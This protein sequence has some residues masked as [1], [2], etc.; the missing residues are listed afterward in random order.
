MSSRHRHAIPQDVQELLAQAPYS[1]VPRFR[2]RLK[3]ARSEKAFAA[4]TKDL[5][6]SVA[7]VD[8]RQAA[9]PS[10][11]YPEALP[12][13][14]YREELLDVIVNNQVVIIAG[15]TG[16]G[17]TTQI[18][19]LCLELG[20]GRRGLIGHTQPRRLA[21]RTVAERIAEELGQDIGESVGYA[22][23]FD[24]RVS[25]STSVKLM[26]DGI[27]LAEMQRDRLLRAYD[28]IIIDEAHERS[29]NIDFLLGYLKQLLPK[30]PELKVI[31]TSAT[32]DPERFAEHF[33]DA[34]GTPAPI[35]EVSGRTY[36]V[37][38]LYRPL[39]QTKGEKTIDVDPL[40]GLIQACKELMS[41]GP[42]DIL[43]FFAG[44][45][46]IR[47]AME[48]IEKQ[49]WKGVEVT[50]LFG[51]LSNQEQHKVF[52]PHAGRRIV[53]A[54]NIAETSLTVPGIHYVVDTGFAR[55]SRYSTRTKVQRL[56]I[57]PISQAS[58]NQRSGRCGRVADGVAI[59][60][61]SEQD[62]QSRPEFT[63][64][65][66]LRTNLAQVILQMASLKLGDIQEF[67]FIQ[68]PD[69]KA[70]RD[71]LLL[72]HELDAL[73]QRDAADPVLTA[74]GKQLARIPLD[75]RLARMLI[76]AQRLGVLFEAYVVVA[77]LTIQDVRERPLEFQAQADQ[78]H[79]RFS[80]KRSDFLSYINLWRYIRTQ[81][82]ELSGNAF[83]KLMQQ[84]F[85]HYMRIREWFDLVR[86]LRSIAE[87]LGWTDV[88]ALPGNID[89]DALHRAVLSGLLSHIGVRD[90]ESR[91]YRGSRN[92]RFAIFPGSSVSKAKPDM[93]MAAEMVETSRLWARDVAQI[94]PAWVEKLGANL[95]KHQYS[96]PFWSSKRAQPMVHQRSTLYGVPVVEDRVIG[97][98]NVDQAAARDMFI[99]E[100]LIAGHWQT[101]HSFYHQNVKKLE[102]A[103]DLEEKAR[104]RDIVVDEETL[105]EFYDA[106]LPARITS[107][108]HFDHWWKKTK[109]QQPDLLDFDP[110]ALVAEHA[111]AVTEEAFPD[112]WRQGSL[113]YK[114]SYQFDPTAPRDGVTIEIPVPLLGGLSPEGF[115]WL[116]P[117]LR[118]ELLTEL[119]R[120]LPKASRRS[121]VPAP[122]F[123]EKA[124]EL[125]TAYQGTVTEQLA[126][127]LQRLGGS[128]IQ[129]SDFQVEKLPA[130]LRFS[131]AA[132][133]KRGKIID[134]DKDLAR[135][136]ERQR[137]KIRSSVSKAARQSESK[138]YK[139]WTKDTIGALEPE[140]HTSVE[141]QT[142]TAYPTLVRTEQGIARKVMP[143]KAQADAQ[144]FS[145]T[146]TM[147]SQDLPQQ[148]AQMLK[149]LP[150]R[151][152]VAVDK[153]PHGGA[154]GLLRDIRIAAIRDLMLEAGG[155]Q[156]TPEGYQRLLEQIRPQLPSAVRQDTVALAPA[157]AAWLDAKQ[158]LEGWEGPA[159]EDMQRQLQLMLPEH[160]VSKLGAQRLKHI[161]RYAKAI[162]L[163]LEDM[164]LHPSRD[165]E[166]QAV[167]NGLEV[168]LARAI[169]NRG[170]KPQIP[171]QTLYSLQWQLQE[172]RVS[173][174]AQ[175]LGTAQT[176]SERKIQ[177]AID[178]L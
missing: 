46:D 8:A 107:G 127:A 76:E 2:A 29:L 56:P 19:K 27:L 43:C 12:V 115:D 119:I 100:A 47:D 80:N 95:L 165:A 32:I 63:D 1:A 40:D 153:Y 147:L 41:Y 23:R 178:A 81:R 131:F 91:E 36:P 156:R 87:Q 97:Y 134:W 162:A 136:Q 145:T 18:P 92:T 141:G 90:G 89:A 177:K 155:P 55:I 114:L 52:R 133:D 38:I 66:I 20:R 123:A 88:K 65:E 103:G 4:I 174:F 25:A 94:D 15:E 164:E 161:P 79:A 72:L 14:A 157:I 84:E 167:V 104:R 116:V 137:Q 57:E 118:E 166:R 9:I 171:A 117:G 173:L 69:T 135:L 35:V 142:V 175:R 16:S 121:V 105:Y 120:S 150:L 24:D 102:A 176:V 50:P 130:H 82:D 129:A 139:Q 51:R 101:H 149:G 7:V 39:E 96:E 74:T 86:Q 11:T 124:A 128:G 126:Q 22:I 42:G 122:A 68:A 78:K 70:I 6:E 99:R 73:E 75:P 112:I 140:V 158:Q 17:K 160:A 154:E 83:R 5:R 143:T 48:M 62:F 21:A 168:R 28:T 151:Q 159:I 98:A 45:S 170:K 85:L 61:Y 138:A 3:K 26:T 106:R 59:R 93:V 49:H 109:Q 132:V 152:R 144:L 113:D 108:R 33:C 53:L 30:R 148:G 146:L 125:I 31:I 111:A 163:R 44:E 172:L 60:L 13:S 77:A 37:E 64:P 34:E 110:E 71:G 58:A 54:T 169:Q 10:M 67:P